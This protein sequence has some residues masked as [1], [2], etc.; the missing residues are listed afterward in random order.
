MLIENKKGTLVKLK[1]CMLFSV[2]SKNVRV[3]SRNPNSQFTKNFS[4]PLAVFA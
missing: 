4:D 3:K 2:S 1:I